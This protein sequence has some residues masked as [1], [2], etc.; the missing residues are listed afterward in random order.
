MKLTVPLYRAC[1]VGLA[2]FMALTF[3]ALEPHVVGQQSTSR[4][5]RAFVR[6]TV[7]SV[8]SVVTREYFDV[9][10]GARVDASL[11]QWLSEGR[12]A[13]AE[14]LESLAAMLTSDL[15]AATQDKHLAV[16]V[17]PAAS[18]APPPSQTSDAS[19]ELGARRSNF[20]IQRVEVLAG[21]VG[22]LNVT[23]FY[24]P[25]E[26]RN[27]ISNAMRFLQ[28]TDALI[29]DMRSNSGGSADTAALLASYLFATA[30][31]PLFEIIPRSGQEGRWYATES[32][33]LPGRNGTRLVY[34]LTAERTFSAGEGFAFILQERRRAE[35]IGERTA[36]AANPGRPYAVS[37]GLELTVPNGQVRAAVSGRNWEGVGVI[38]DV[39]VTASDALRVG[40]IRALRGLL[41]QAPSGLWHEALKRQIAALEERR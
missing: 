8:A 28:Y 21:N 3:T 20:G 23:A 29:L 9:S 37:A 32:P 26:A 19:R 7:E 12:Y 25:E 14:T 33:P 34:V 2:M 13:N 41:Q 6:E 40:H 30:K 5:D 16:S 35:V 11:R 27:A 36:G 15:L 39:R 1:V 22:Y 4:I 17:V 18:V 24:R 38:P 31:L 10:V